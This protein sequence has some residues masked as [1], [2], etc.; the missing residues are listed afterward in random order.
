MPDQQKAVIDFLGDHFRAVHGSLKVITTHVSVIFLSGDKAYKMKRAVKF[1]FLDFR[2]LSARRDACEKELEINRRTA[3]TLYLAVTPVTSSEDGF[4]LGGAGK[5]VEWLVEMNRFDEDT[6]FDRLAAIERGLRRPIIEDLADVIAD[7][8]AHGEISN[9]R[10]GFNGIRKIA[11]NNVQSFDILPAG[12][13]DADLVKTVTTKTLQ[14]IDALQDVLEARRQAGKVRACHGDLHLRNICLVGDKPTLFDAIE[15]S[16]DFSEIDVLYDL[17]FLLMDLDFHGLRRLAAFLLNRYLDVGAESA[18]AFR[19]LPVFLSMRAQIRAHVGAAIAASQDNPADRE[20]EMEAADR[21][22]KCALGYLNP[23]PPRLVAVGGLSGSGKSR[24]AREIASHLGNAPGARVVR[25]DVV[26]KRLS[27]IH[28]NQ[29][30]GA[31]GYTPEMTEKT[32]QHFFAEAKAAMASGQCAVLDAVFASA[33]HRARAEALAVE[34]G[35]PFQGLWVDAPEEVRVHRVETRKRNVSDVTTE[36]ARQQ[37]EYQLGAVN[38]PAI[39]SAGKKKETVRQALTV[40]G[41]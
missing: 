6:Q 16:P 39:S 41:P 37:S 33:G 23:L 5:P 17:A 1:P 18:D 7:F 14:D 27:G 4:E 12:L 9:T 28:P 11:E 13:F 25:T 19:V 20:R 36:I 8:H 38:W 40:L 34:C 22:L 10:G 15:F 21:Y 29:S 26:R 24:L 32:Y 3:P 30:L 31:D 35:V 2:T